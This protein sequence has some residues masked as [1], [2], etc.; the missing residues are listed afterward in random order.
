MKGHLNEF[1]KFWFLVGLEAS[2]GQKTVTDNAVVLKSKI[3][4]RVFFQS[5]KLVE[6]RCRAGF[7]KFWL[8]VDVKFLIGQ[9]F[10]NGTWIQKERH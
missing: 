1:V 10:E 9:C 8:F 3:Q 2:V 5:E 7:W 6:F 4:V